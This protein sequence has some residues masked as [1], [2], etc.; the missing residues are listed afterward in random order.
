MIFSTFFNF[1]IIIIIIGFSYIF[2]SYLKKEDNEIQNLDLLYGLFVLVFL[3]LVFNFILPLNFYFYPIAIIGFFSFIFCIYEKKMKINLFYYL[4]IIFIFIF[5]IYS[6]GDNV[7]SP[8]Y[9]HQIIKWLH[10]YKISLGLSNLE[11]RF[12]DNSLW[13]NFLSLFKFKFKEFNSIYTLNIIPF[14]LLTYEI[15]KQKKTLSYLFLT[16]SISF[17][18]FFSYLHPSQNGVIFNHLHNPE[19]D[20]IGMVFFIFSFYLLLM[21]LEKKEIKVFHLLILSSSICFFVK[22]SY[23]GVALLPLLILI[24]F[25][26]KNLISILKNKLIFF[27]ILLFNFWLIKNLLASG[28]FVFPINFTCINLAWSPGTDE[29]EFYKN[30]IKGFARDTRERLRYLDFNHTIHTFNWILPWFKDYALNTSL[31]KIS[32][33]IIFVSTICF[34][35]LKRYSNLI[36]INLENG[37]IHLYVLFVLL[38][39]LLIWFQAPEIRFGWGTIISLN[40]YL[41]SILIF[42]NTIFEKINP[43]IIKY[44]TI[45]FIMI[46]IF[47]NK[48]NFNTQNLLNPYSPKIDYSKI[49]KIFD[50]E[51][52]SVYKSTNWRCYDFEEICVN[53]IKDDYFLEKKF[54][55][56][57]FTKY[58]LIKK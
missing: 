43:K 10:K 24:F 23:A 27:V 8:M 53:T 38:I 3:S 6:N 42:Y 35:I 4:L 52:R 30:V 9:H 26:K 1:F 15:F 19:V 25:Y 37:K 5:I 29:I 57:I 48:K 56:L 2:K 22:L 45:F 11:I 44:F 39:N 50:L 47:D 51:D 21:F 31:L 12:G 13:F 49:I 18:F 20:T 36:V 46:L 14:T 28:C 17:L 33:I 55:Y 7:D 16:L 32:Y 41:L 40:C 34:I 58:K 54:G